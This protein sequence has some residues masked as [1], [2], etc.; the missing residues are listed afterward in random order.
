MVIGWVL[1]GPRTP[2]LMVPA[3]FMASLPVMVAIPQ[4]MFVSLVTGFWCLA[5]V[6][7]YEYLAERARRWQ[8]QGKC[9]ACGYSLKDINTELCPECGVDSV[10]WMTRFDKGRRLES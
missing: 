9:P 1:L 7:R 2:R 8:E 10:E 4:L 6:V 5:R 3:V